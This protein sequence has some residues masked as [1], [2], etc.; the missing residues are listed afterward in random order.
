MRR[1]GLAFL[2]ASTLGVAAMVNARG[3]SDDELLALDQRINELSFAAKYSELVPLRHRYLEMIEARHGTDTPEYGIALAKLG[4][5][6]QAAD[7]PT[8]AEL[9]LQRASGIAESW[10]DDPRL[11]DLLNILSWRLGRPEASRLLRRALAIAEKSFGLDHPNV[12]R[13]LVDL[14]ILLDDRNEAEALMRRAVAIEEKHFGPDHPN[15]AERLNTLA[16]L[17]RKINRHPEA[18][19]LLRRAFD[20]YE[21][22]SNQVDLTNVLA[23]LVWVLQERKRFTDA[24]P[25]IRRALVFQERHLG[26]DHAEIAPRL[27]IL[28]QVLRAGN[29]LAEAEL[30]LRRAVAIYEKERDDAL[31]PQAVHNLVRLLRDTNRHAEADEL[32]RSWSRR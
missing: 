5:S 6:L 20:I 2:L 13:P 27:N 12:A 22:G 28:S 30:V 1:H 16:L 18:E 23:N 21:K 19:A 3:Q 7:R 4:G 11:V 8:E 24:E 17:L 25:L 14:A 10:P 29:R 32:L 9:V 31:T 15:V 26:P